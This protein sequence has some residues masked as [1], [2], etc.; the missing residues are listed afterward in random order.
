MHSLQYSTKILITLYNY[1]NSKKKIHCILICIILSTLQ[2]LET[3]GGGWNKLVVIIVVTYAPGHWHPWKL[4]QQLPLQS[5]LT[6]ENICVQSVF[7]LAPCKIK[8]HIS[9]SYP[10]LPGTNEL[11][12]SASRRFKLYFFLHLSQIEVDP[13]ETLNKET[14]LSCQNTAGLHITGL[15]SGKR[16]YLQHNC[17]G[18]TI[19]YH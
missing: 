13:L 6:R 15:I 8:N 3:P 17:V 2:W 18:D 7:V 19:V 4:N 11:K 16:W 1:G 10:D 5:S 12:I 14:G 9:K